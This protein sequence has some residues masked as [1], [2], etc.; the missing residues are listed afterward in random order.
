M[1][2][3]TQIVIAAIAVSGMLLYAFPA[4]QFASAATIAIPDGEETI[5]QDQ[6]LAQR[7]VDD[8]DQRIRQTQE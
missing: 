6:D 3:N 8:T 7:I 5:N 4:Q 1:T 2:R